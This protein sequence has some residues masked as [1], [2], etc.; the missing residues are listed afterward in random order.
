LRFDRNRIIITILLSAGIYLFFVG[1]FSRSIADNDL[2]GYLSFGRVFWEEGYFPFRDTF[3]Y[4]PTKPLW[5]YHEW[6][7]GVL[8]YGIYK[9]S[10][11]AGLQLFRYIA[12]LLT[13]YLIYL[14]ALKK[15]GRPLAAATALIPAML[16][17]SFGY[18]PV[19]AQM[20]TYLF[21]ILTIYILESAKKNQIWSI[22]WLLLPIQILWCNL[23]GG[24]VAGLGLIGLYA[25]GEGFSR[26]RAIPY[27]KVGV[28]ATLV[29]V[30]NPYGIEYW[31]YMI[32]AVSMPR[33][34]IGEWMS[35][36]AAVKSHF[37]ELPV[38]IFLFMALLCLL[39]FIFSRKKNLTDFFILTIT[40]YLGGKHIR[41]NIMFGL[42]FGA[43]V[44]VMLSEYWEVWKAKS[45]FF[46]RHS[47]VPRLLPVV[48]LFS[49]Y[50]LINPSLS[51]TPVPSFALLTPASFFPV[52]AVS[53]IKANDI[54]GNILPHFDWGEYLIWTC[55]P[56]CRVAMDGRYE[57]VYKDQVSREYFD[58]L[59]GREKWDIFLRKYPHDMILIKSNTRTHQLMLRE[60]SWRVA[61]E[62]QWCVLFLKNT[63]RA[64]K[65]N[66]KDK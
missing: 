10:G 15:G 42:V 31:I 22:L 60:P 29:T 12:I 51:L 27:I 5:V 45:L 34:D 65:D 1:I 44:P 46:T 57:T 6:L 37:Q 28:F 54:R 43:Y 49:L 50:L 13:I 40:I 19:R 11:P 8:F 56:A 4:T 62:D 25:L 16:L 7:T 17:V 55:Y 41:H 39:L 26:R 24:F 48:L 36:M 3:S 23:H 33:P 64:M 21:F 9:Y 53:W 32:P 52:G 63:N 66:G 58:F 35:V 38:F 30:A 18:V 14:T 61:Y 20:F 2:W 47:W 59:T